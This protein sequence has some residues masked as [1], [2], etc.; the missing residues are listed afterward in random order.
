M[1]VSDSDQ[2]LKILK[3]TLAWKQKTD[4]KSFTELSFNSQTSASDFILVFLIDSYSIPILVVS[5]FHAFNVML[6]QKESV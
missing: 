5:V 6:F 3:M 2:I 4:L 1:I